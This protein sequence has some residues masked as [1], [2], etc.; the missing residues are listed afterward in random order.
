AFIAVVLVMFLV[1]DSYLTAKAKEVDSLSR[2]AAQHL[3]L[4]RFDMGHD[5]LA[6]GGRIFSALEA[7][8]LFMKHPF[9]LGLMDNRA[10]DELERYGGDYYIHLSSAFF[11]WLVKTGFVGI[12]IFLMIFLVIWREIRDVVGG[13]RG[14]HY[15]VALSFIAMGIHGLSSGDWIDPMFLLVMAYLVSHR[16]FLQGEKG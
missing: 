15:Y 5:E 3:I 4:M 1:F 16:K 13:K 7:A 2:N 6:Y 14:I 12:G 9:G 8:R 11:S 10:I